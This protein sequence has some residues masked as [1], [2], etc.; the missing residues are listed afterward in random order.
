MTALRFAVV[1]AGAIARAYEAA[2]QSLK[3][4]R[5]AAVCDVDANAVAAFAERVG[6]PGYTSLGDLLAHEDIDAAVV[7]SPPATHEEIS[8][9]LLD[10]GKHVLC[11]KPL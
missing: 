7:C 10:A 3:L 4:G 5:V 1:G 6:C 2:F 8:C 9:Q 11:E